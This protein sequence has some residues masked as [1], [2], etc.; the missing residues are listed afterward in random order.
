MAN[1][2]TSVLNADGTLNPDFKAKLTSMLNDLMGKEEVQFSSVVKEFV[3]GQI[4]DL[5][6]KL[7]N[8]TKWVEAQ[9]NINALLEVFDANKDGELS[10][11]E[12][13]S[14]FGE[15]KNSTVTNATSIAN[16]SSKLEENVK[17]ITA[18]VAT[19]E[20][21]VEG[22]KADLTKTTA[23]FSDKIAQAKT[24]IATNTEAI[25]TQLTGSIDDVK[26]NVTKVEADLT[27]KIAE[28]KKDATD[29]VN[30]LKTSIEGQVDTVK[31]KVTEVAGKLGA[32]DV[33]VTGAV[34]AIEGIAE[35]FVEA[36]G[37]VEDRISEIRKAFGLKVPTTTTTDDGAVV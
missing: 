16:V 14:K 21:K 37:K 2:D 28:A 34:A 4:S 5:E 32:T 25:K 13:L 15:I 17:N 7:V 8:N 26:G 19:V 12:V 1:T 11:A 30:G 18:S 9:K 23:D 3:D 22:V 20:A 6:N 36:A 29:S 33:K 35:A 24:D 27:S 31:G 10:P